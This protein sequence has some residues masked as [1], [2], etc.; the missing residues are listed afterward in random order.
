MSKEYQPRK[1]SKIIE[2]M[3][4]KSYSK[5]FVSSL[6]KE[7]DEEVRRREKV[8]RIFPNEESTIRPIGAILI[9]INE[10]WIISSKLYIRLK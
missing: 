1:V 4:G 2:N 5:S 9:D 3:C 6:T 7:L 8:I 10:D